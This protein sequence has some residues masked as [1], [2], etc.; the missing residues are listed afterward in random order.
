M[1]QAK[2]KA[3]PSTRKPAG[4]GIRHTLT[5]R[6]KTDF[7]HVSDDDPE[8]QYY[9]MKNDGGRIQEALRDGW[10][11]VEG[12]SPGGR[13]DPDAKKVQTDEATP[14]GGVIR[15]SAGRRDD[16]ELILMKTSKENY[17]QKVREPV[18]QRMAAIDEALARGRDQSGMS[19]DGNS[20][21]PKLPDGAGRGLSE[22]KSDTLE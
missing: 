17:D 2:R 4:K 3:R 6:L 5:K 14:K 16:S 18:R 8:N 19:D 11:P 7:S 22:Y 13:W 21:A 15:L 20:Y 10:E 1:A 12:A 9:L